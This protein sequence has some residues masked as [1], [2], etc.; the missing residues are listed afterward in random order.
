[1]FCCNSDLC[2]DADRGL[3]NANFVRHACGHPSR[4]MLTLS[5]LSAWPCPPPAL[6]TSS[7]SSPSDVALLQTLP[8]RHL[9]TNRHLH[10]HSLTL[11]HDIRRLLS[12]LA[13][14]NGELCESRGK[15]SRIAFGLRTPMRVEVSTVRPA[16]CRLENLLLTDECQSLRIVDFGLSQQ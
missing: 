5:Q 9:S 8:T 2:F 14:E 3:C 7:G 13:H 15:T 4:T 12:P 16:G 1:M 6:E 11:I 10:L